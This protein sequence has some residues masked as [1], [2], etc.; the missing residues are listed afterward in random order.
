MATEQD[1][2]VPAPLRP[3]RPAG[4]KTLP[5]DLGHNF[6]T[7]Y[8]MAQGAA[9]NAQ[10]A[11]FLGSGRMVGADYTAGR[12]QPPSSPSAAFRIPNG[13]YWIDGSLVEVEDPTG[14]LTV[15]D[16][17]EEDGTYHVY[18]DA[19][20]EGEPDLE[21]VTLVVDPALGY[22]SQYVEDQTRAYLGTIT[23]EGGVVTTVDGSASDYLQTFQTLAKRF[24]VGG[25][26]EGEAFDPST[27]FAQLT[28][29]QARLI[30]LE[31]NEG[32]GVAAVPTSVEGLQREV[33]AMQGFLL[34]QFPGMA[35]YLTTAWDIPGATGN[36]EP[37]PEGPARRTW[38]GGNAVRDFR[39][40]AIR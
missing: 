35:E 18:A 6:R 25:G 20:V 31:D 21:T 27:I 15:I 29:I 23:V 32:G 30:A 19:L 16:V 10:A 33:M 1:Y 39:Q 12:I 26:D 28:D 2:A 24:Y 7:L 4:W 3:I 13:R 34:A 17:P 37:L 38:A 14:A 22:G 40:K 5:E 36:R 8:D 9:S 11:W